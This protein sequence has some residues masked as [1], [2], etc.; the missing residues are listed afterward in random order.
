MS[1]YSSQASNKLKVFCFFLK[2]KKGVRNSL[3]PD[4][5]FDAYLRIKKK[6]I[7]LDQY[8]LIGLNSLANYLFALIFLCTNCN[9]NSEVFGKVV[10]SLIVI[11]RHK[12]HQ[13]ECRV[14]F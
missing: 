11:L 1:T 13:F 8:K 7:L 9:K 14:F 3:D 6:K 10:R 4:I 2:G 12:L 5:A